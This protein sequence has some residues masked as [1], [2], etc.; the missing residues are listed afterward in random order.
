LNKTSEWYTAQVCEAS[1]VRTSSAK[2][3]TWMVN[4][5]KVHGKR[6]IASLEQVHSVGEV[7]GSGEK[8][9]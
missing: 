6:S 4:C 5:R 2:M 3:S 9:K 1:P 8:P 7:E